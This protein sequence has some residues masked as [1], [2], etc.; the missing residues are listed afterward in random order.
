MNKKLKNGTKDKSTSTANSKKNRSS[1]FRQN[2]I[3][4]NQKNNQKSCCAELFDVSRS[5]SA[6]NTSF[7]ASITGNIFPI[8]TAFYLR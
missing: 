8:L 3:P 2:S 7:S 5:E 1:N 6:K 4:I